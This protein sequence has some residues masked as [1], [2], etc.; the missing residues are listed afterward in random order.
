MK[1][2]FYNG[3]IIDTADFKFYEALAIDQGL[4]VAKGTLEHCQELVGSETML[5]DLCGQT[6]LPGFNDSH[7]H[8]LGYG[9]SLFQVD[10]VPAR[11]LEDLVYLSQ[12]FLEDNALP[13][14]E[15]LLG[16]GWNQD[17]FDFPMLPS[18]ETLDQISTEHPIFLR[19]ACGHIGAANTL[20]LEL[21]GLWDNPPTHVDGGHVDLGFDNKPT[22]ILRENAMDLLLSRI[23][24]PSQT[25]LASYI[26]QAEKALF[27]GG[28]TSVQSDDLCV[29]PMADSPLILKTFEDMGL[30]GRLKISVHEQSLMRTSAHLKERIEAG[31][32]YQ[33]SFGT[34][35]Y[36]P[37]KILGDGSLGARTAYL[38]SAYADD[39]ESQGI[40][41]YT[42]D[43]LSDLV[44]TAFRN[45]I[46]VA[47][48]GIGDG[49]IDQ[50][51][52]A[53]EQGLRGLADMP[54]LGQAASE[55]P[56]R[57]AIVHCQITDKSLLDRM[58][59][60]N[61]IAMVQPIF[62]DYDLHMVEDRVGKERARETYAFKTMENMGIPTAYGTD[63]PVEGYQVFRG[64]QCAVTRQD[65]KHQPL[66]GWL[67]EEAVTI[68]EAL[69][70]YTLGSAYASGEE[71][72][73][74]ALGIGMAADLVILDQ[75]PLHVP[76]ERLSEIQVTATFKSGA[77]VYSWK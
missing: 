43:E 13:K 38:R 70:A 53:I 24:T 48:H 2:I 15:W 21:V 74:G 3:A 66:G 77:L 76:A 42:Q 51:L 41:M 56:L 34:F 20:A 40:A 25:V 7:M 5:L 72:N 55:Q 32:V 4:I 16:R 61:A 19:R 29:F 45:G 30:S 67:P 49:M 57:N 64:I 6:L 8:L 75:N 73:K 31:Y 68:Q 1:T 44:L 59:A 12:L 23:P 26:E 58:K 62:L 28:I 52:T 63:C 9:Q 54:G 37:L 71:Q 22:G 39:P 35:S 50:A 65:L 36:G 69:R 27:S 47:I 14:G 46:P 10:L 11:S 60:V 33:K 17:Y 18:R